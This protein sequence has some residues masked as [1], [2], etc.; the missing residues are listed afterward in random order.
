MGLLVEDIRALDALICD[1][2]RILRL[3]PS[4]SLSWHYSYRSAAPGT[5]PL[6][7]GLIA[8]W[9]LSQFLCHSKISRSRFL[10]R[11]FHKSFL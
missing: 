7:G 11:S 2:F 8:S 1:L 10:T 3:I 9:K 4:L 5:R 6:R